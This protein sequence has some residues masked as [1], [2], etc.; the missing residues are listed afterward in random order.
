MR[1]NRSPGHMLSPLAFYY[2]V[3]DRSYIP[4]GRIVAETL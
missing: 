1:W 4:P 3:G 2:I